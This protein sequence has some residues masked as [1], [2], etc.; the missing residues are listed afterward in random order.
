MTELPFPSVSQGTEPSQAKDAVSPGRTDLAREVTSPSRADQPEADTRATPD[1][2]SAL[3]REATARG[4]DSALI[5]DAQPVADSVYGASGPAAADRQVAQ[6]SGGAVLGHAGISRIEGLIGNGSGVGPTELAAIHRELIQIDSGTTSILLAGLSDAQLAGWMQAA[7]DTYAMPDGSPDRR[8]ADNTLRTLSYAGTEET[9]RIA[10]VLAEPNRGS[11]EP[12]ERFVYDMSSQIYGAERDA[13][14]RD[15][16]SKLDTRPELAPIAA[17]LLGRESNQ[18]AR[19]QASFDSYVAE[20]G[21]DT[22]VTILSNSAT[23]YMG[24]DGVNAG[25]S[26]AQQSLISM[27]HGYEGGA[28]PGQDPSLPRDVASDEIRAQFV[29]A[30]FDL[31]ASAR[32]LG[33]EGSARVISSYA[34][35]TI[36]KDPAGLLARL[37]AQVDPFSDRFGAA[38]AMQIELGGGDR[39][40]ELVEAMLATRAPGQ[41]KAQWLEANDGQNARSLNYLL[42]AV[43]EGLESV[44]TTQTAAAQAET[45]KTV[46]STLAGAA[47][48]S[49]WVGPV[50]E[51]G[52]HLATDAYVGRLTAEI[53]AGTRRASEQI[54]QLGLPRDEYGRLYEGPMRDVLMEGLGDDRGN[55]G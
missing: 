31:A 10:E 13:A 8:T 27:L 25:P 51:G 32:E 26:I 54:V 18:T 35:R 44:E 45:F 29:L 12:L 33:D 17:S 43:Q 46:V 16:V 40:G 41:T 53:E 1:Y 52:V 55:N 4:I 11:V 2:V 49:G 28:L 20:F 24:R 21:M 19:S 42:N 30:T 7:R 5:R 6:A 22:M 38:I 9:M 14:L 3:F 50:V 48:F 39:A 15:V 47:A 37:D 36:E 23:P 34:M